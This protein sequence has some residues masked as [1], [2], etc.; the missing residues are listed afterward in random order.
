M[1]PLV[2]LVLPILD[3]TLL[4]TMATLYIIRGNINLM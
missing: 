2:P 4:D 1:I 3:V